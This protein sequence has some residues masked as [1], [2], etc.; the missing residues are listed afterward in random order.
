MQSLSFP[1]PLST[2][3]LVETVIELSKEPSTRTWDD[4]L[5]GVSGYRTHCPRCGAPFSNQSRADIQ[6]W[7][8]GWP[9]EGLP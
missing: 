9:E 6:C 5:R 7:E 1:E 8:C 2:R 3:H 4:L